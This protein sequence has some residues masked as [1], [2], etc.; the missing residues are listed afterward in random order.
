MGRSRSIW[1]TCLM[2]TTVSCGADDDT[3]SPSSSSSASTTEVPA[4]SS[5]SSTTTATAP[6]T[7]TGERTTTTASTTTTGERTTTTVS[8]TT[9]T[10]PAQTLSVSVP[11]SDPIQLT[12][13]ATVG[14]TYSGFVFEPA[15]FSVSTG[16]AASVTAVGPAGVCEPSSDGVF[17]FGSIGDACEIGLHADADGG[18]GAADYT[19]SVE[20][21]SAGVLS[22]TIASGPGRIECFRPGEEIDDLV[23]AA[24]AGSLPLGFNVGVKS[25]D[26]M[27]EP[28]ADQIGDDVVIA[29]DPFD[30]STVGTEP[31]FTVGY[32]VQ[33]QSLY[34]PDEDI[35]FTWR[36]SDDCGA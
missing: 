17:V 13:D 27:P 18:F 26:D 15:P 8:T 36:V 3:T 32:I 4:T 29:F 5:A 24:V 16:A 28:F 14:V 22:W 12:G 2:I 21:R 7:T 10:L 34:V 33:G 30:P 1:L 6:T 31:T 23:L 11:A 19:L 35:E 25:F 20:L 9:T